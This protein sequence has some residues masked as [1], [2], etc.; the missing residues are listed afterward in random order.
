MSS[1]ST[2]LAGQPKPTL[3]VVAICKDEEQDLPTFINHLLPWIDEVVIVDDGSVDSSKEIIRAAGP[4]VRL[5]KQE[6]DPE[7]GFAGLRNSGIDNASSDWLLHTD[8]DERIPP[9]LAAE[10]K[11]TIRD[12]SLN[13]FKY[14]RRNYFLHRAMRGGGWQD[15]NKPQL[16]RKGNHH[17]KNRVHERCVVDGEP[18]SV[19][20]LQNVIWHLNDET[21]QERMEKSMVYCQ[22]QARRIGERNIVVRWWHMFLFPVGEFLRKYILKKGWRDGT[23]GLLFSM[24]SSCAMF[25]AC[26]LLWDEQNRIE[27][28]ELEQ[29]LKADWESSEISDIDRE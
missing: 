22:E 27:R 3:G 9:A 4:K 16:A 20:Q 8:I 28:D 7:T 14:P 25:K 24:H 1:Q 21:Y 23:H 18:G 15:W 13:A 19:G 11:L 6:M 2:N 10:I 17:F 5:V 29:A 12:T 26:A